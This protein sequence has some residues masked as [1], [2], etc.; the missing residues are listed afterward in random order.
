V[1]LSTAERGSFGEKS[2]AVVIQTVIFDLGGVLIED[3]SAGIITY[4]ANYFHVN[5]DSLSEA[6]R[7]YWDA[8][9]KG[10]L[11]EQELWEHVTTEV[12]IHNPPYNSPWRDGFKQAYREKPEMLLLLKQLK[13]QGFTTALLSNIEAP[14][15][16]YFKQYPL[17][18]IDRYFFSCEMGLRKP[19]MGIYALALQG[20]ECQPG[21]VVFIDD[22]SENVEAAIYL[23]IPSIL[24]RTCV[25]LKEQLLR[26][27]IIL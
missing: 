14:L 18:D 26:L 2:G 8:W 3:P 17:E 27:Q 21:D 23:G 13:Q 7:K 5:R 1:E 15:V 25:A 16:S 10:I 6:L 4:C 19:E 24:F 12:Q 11:S 22:R 9:Q 20:L